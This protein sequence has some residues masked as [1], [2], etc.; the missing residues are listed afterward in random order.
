MAGR[1]VFVVILAIGGAVLGAFWPRIFPPRETCAEGW[2][3]SAQSWGDAMSVARQRGDAALANAIE[4]QLIFTTSLGPLAGQRDASG[5]L[6]R[7]LTIGITSRDEW[8][9]SRF[10]AAQD[11]TRRAIIACDR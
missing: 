8:I 5:R 11:E 10:A 6:G 1:R 3:R 9:V 2:R 7:F 4:G